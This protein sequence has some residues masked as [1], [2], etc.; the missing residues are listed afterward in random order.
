MT[1]PPTSSPPP[2]LDVTDTGGSVR[3][4]KKYLLSWQEG[5]ELERE[6]EQEK[7]K[8]KAGGLF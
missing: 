4:Q 2:A 7:K 6:I 1:Q 3:M 8:A 5:V